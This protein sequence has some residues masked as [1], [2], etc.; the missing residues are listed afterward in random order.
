[1]GTFAID[2]LTGNLFI[3]NKNFES[4]GDTT[5]SGSTYPEVNNYSELPLP[6]SSYAGEVYLVRNSTGNYVVNRKDAGFYYSN[7]TSWVLLPQITPYFNSTNF[8][9]FDNSDNTKGISFITSG[10]T[11]GNFR[12]LT[13][14]DLDGTIAYLSNIV[15]AKINSINTN[16]GTTISILKNLNISSGLTVNGFTSIE[17]GINFKRTEVTGTTYTPLISDIIIGIKATSAYTVTINLPQ[18]SSI[19]QVYWIFKDE[20]FLSY[21][22]PITFSAATGNYIEQTNSVQ[23]K[24]NGGSIT[25]YNDNNLNW[26]IV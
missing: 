18:I 20:G 25:I 19:G 2:I 7:G 26:F 5:T 10:L 24:S 13:V 1:M 21:T 23:L 22:N 15:N 11:T 12:K 9:V 16:T 3:F 4:S 17:G 14:Q 6:A 8:Q